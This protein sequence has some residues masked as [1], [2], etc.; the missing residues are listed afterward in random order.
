MQPDNLR[1]PRQNLLDDQQQE[2]R[3]KPLWNQHLLCCGDHLQ[4]IPSK[5]NSTMSQP[6]N[7]ASL[8]WYHHTNILY[9][10]TYIV[11]VR[12]FQYVNVIIMASGGWI[13]R[14]NKSCPFIFF[15]RETQKHIM[16]HVYLTTRFYMSLGA[17]DQ[18]HIENNIYR[19]QE[20]VSSDSK[21][22]FLLV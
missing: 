8:G 5:S 17:Q 13:L 9:V 2:H 19:L 15:N 7:S 22:S 11:G 6:F 14:E 1:Q 21:P 4:S 16:C 3:W 12:Y 18:T 10:S 20:M